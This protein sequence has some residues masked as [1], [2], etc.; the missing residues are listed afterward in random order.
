MNARPARWCSATGIVVG[1]AVV[2]DVL[3]RFVTVEAFRAEGC[4]NCSNP[5]QVLVQSDVSSGNWN[6]RDAEAREQPPTS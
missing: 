4:W 5:V 3:Y 2:D 1:G 6:R